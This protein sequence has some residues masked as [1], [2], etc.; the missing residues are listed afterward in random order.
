MV[1]ENFEKILKLF[2]ENSVENLNFYLFLGKFVAKNRAIG[3]NII[4]LQQYFP[5]G[6]G[7]EHHPLRTPLPPP[8]WPL[9]YRNKEI[10][11]N[12]Q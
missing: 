10:G 2:D 6:G 11:L 7:F 12:F 4:F 1:G 5:V 9:N 8:N 3:N